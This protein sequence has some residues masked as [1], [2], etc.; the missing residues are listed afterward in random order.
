MSIEVYFF[1]LFALGILPRGST[2]KR[3][4]GNIV[5]AAVFHAICF[6]SILMALYLLGIV[7]GVLFVY[8][9]LMCL[10]EMHHGIL[11]PATYEPEQHWF[12]RF[13]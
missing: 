8:P 7:V 12:R 10:F 5:A 2:N 13:W 4:R 3:P 1:L 6:F 11:T 9:N